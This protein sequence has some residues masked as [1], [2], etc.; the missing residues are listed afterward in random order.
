MDG[1]PL[2]PYGGIRSLWAGRNRRNNGESKP[3][4]PSELAEGGTV[5][6]M[7]LLLGAPHSA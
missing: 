7:N 4:F 1:D 3:L 2:E 6:K 5:R